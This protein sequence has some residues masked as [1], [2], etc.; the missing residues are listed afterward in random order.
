MHLT[1]G[2]RRKGP[3]IEPG[4]APVP[5][6]PPFRVQ[7]G[8]QLLGRHVPGVIPHPPQDCRQLFRQDKAGVHRQH[9]PQLE[10][11]T[12]QMRQPVGQTQRVGGRQQQLRHVRPSA[13]RQGAQPARRHAARNPRGDAAKPQ[14][15]FDPAC[16]YSRAP[17]VILIWQ[18]RL[19]S[20]LP[21]TW[22]SLLPRRANSAARGKMAGDGDSQQ[23]PGR[24]AACAGLSQDH[25]PAALWTGT[26][27]PSC[28]VDPQA[29]GAQ[30]P[31]T[32]L[33]RRDTKAQCGRIGRAAKPVGGIR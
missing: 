13:L 16:G 26:S 19:R 20:V 15:T 25:I 4:K 18:R 22:G 6:R 14:Q 29:P 17:V 24:S 21:G 30:K 33:Q 7:H 27:P 11:S 2:G 32:L 23:A 3:H 1:D 12:T 28:P 31:R 8:L 9:L 10:R 5:A